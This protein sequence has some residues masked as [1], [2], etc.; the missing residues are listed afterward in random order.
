MEVRFGPESRASVPLFRIVAHA[1]LRAAPALVPTFPVGVPVVP[2]PRSVETT[3]DT[4]GL[5]ACATIAIPYVSMNVTLLISRSVVT[6]ARSFMT[7]DSR[8]NVMPWS[9]AA[10][11]ISDV[12]RLSRIIS[13][14]FSLKSSS[15]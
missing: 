14:I 12:D 11:L 9:R 7:A 3:L 13:R 8:R 10:R 2:T 1:F 6:P 15:S 4:A 5:E